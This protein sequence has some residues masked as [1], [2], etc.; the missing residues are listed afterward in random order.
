MRQTP[1][2]VALLVPNLGLAGFEFGQR[3]GFCSAEFGQSVFPS[4]KIRRIAAGN[5]HF[6]FK[7]YQF[8][9]KN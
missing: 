5:L 4:K 3:H 1:V 8:L 2:V 6:S 7:M 9:F